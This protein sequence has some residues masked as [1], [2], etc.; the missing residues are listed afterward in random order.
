MFASVAYERPP[1]SLDDWRT[2][3][4]MFIVLAGQLAAIA[5]VL[6]LV[7]S[8]LIGGKREPGQTPTLVRVGFILAVIVAALAYSLWGGAYLVGKT[9]AGTSQY[10]LLLIRQQ[11]IGLL[12]G[13]AA[14]LIAVLLPFVANLLHCRPS[15]I[16]ALSKLSFK[17]AVRRKVL[18][19][20]LAMLLVVL[21]SS[22]FIQSH[23]TDQVRTYVQ[24]ISLS[25]TI[26]LLL[27]AGLLAS[28][29]IPTDMK[30][31]T[32]HTI[33]TKPVE[34]FEIVVGRFLGYV[35]LLTIALVAV[36][37][38]SL[39]YVLRGIDPDAA[40][41]SLKA[42]E[43][44]Y[45]E[46]EFEGTKDPKQATNVGKEWNYRSWISGPEPR[47]PT[48]Y[49]IWKFGD[50]RGLHDRKKVRLEFAFD[51]YRTTKGTIN[52]GVFCTFL[53][54][55]ADLD[56]VQKQAYDNERQKEREKNN[57]D[58]DEIDDRLAEKYGYYELAS[59]EIRNLHTYFVDLP[60]GLFRHAAARPVQKPAFPAAQQADRPALMVKVRCESR[61][62]YVGVAK[63]DLYLRPDYDFGLS[64]EEAAKRDQMRF[65]VNF[66]K[67]QSGLWFSLCLVV[68]V[69]VALSTYLS[70][71]ITF[72]ATAA[73]FI[74]GL[75]REFIR[76]IAEGVTGVTG[77]PFESAYRLAQ[78][79]LGA[80]LEETSA[81]KFAGYS[82]DVYRLIVR[83]LI[84]LL[85]D[86]DRF[87][88][89][90]LVG[91]GFNIGAG[92]LSMTAILLAGY[93]ILCALVGYYLIKW[94]EIA[95]S[96]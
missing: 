9:A 1:L 6:W 44:T 73:L 58:L 86:V 22:W 84:N 8:R 48:Q 39:L 15:R 65:M 82:D 36:S 96:M 20:F 55:A 80:P 64:D 52:K 79:D 63:Y 90:D 23:P 32:I 68:G 66:V 70:G 2:G 89:S 24:V 37:A 77:G 91:E 83:R 16:W 26:L 40:Y 88:F 18:W 51:L 81:Y 61:T 59:K 62:Q 93:M 25:M 56:P 27:V 7:L 17:E 46:L 60:G 4:Q 69:A 31:Q 14:A 5:I 71:L 57:A 47:Q 49:A 76:T 19:V 21:F 34:R 95:S 42:R 78:R 72:L 75:L 92:Q 33:V 53:V 3:V 87:N 74:G 45:G 54:L 41:E 67:G 13:G 29:G 85:P 12:V 10:R 50:I 43:T 30:N 28:F 38:V 11:N 35:A 94:R